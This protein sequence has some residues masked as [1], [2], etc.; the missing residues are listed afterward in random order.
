MPTPGS[1]QPGSLNPK[2]YRV[3]YF[4]ANLSDAGD[5]GMLELLETEALEGTNKILLSKDKFSFQ[6]NFFIVITYLEKR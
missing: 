2:D 1:S 3:R 4:K 6:D 5:L